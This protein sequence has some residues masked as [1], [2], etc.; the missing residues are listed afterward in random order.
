MTT[1]VV[2]RK[3][4]R[5]C[6]GADSLAKYG[7]TLESATYVANHDKLVCVGGTWI[8]PTGPASAQLIL[9]SYFRA[10]EI[11]PDFTSAQG[12]FE[13]FTDMMGALKEDYFLIPKEDERDPY[14]SLQMEMLLA[15]PAGIFG[16]YPLRSVQEFTRFYA[17]GSGAEL[18]LGAMHAVYEEEADVLRI[19]TK[20]LAA[21]AE[22]DDST[23][24]PFSLRE[25]ALSPP[26]MPPQAG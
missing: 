24:A 9:T 25:V 17:F 12:I 19:A 18:A 23:A 11:Q 20:G 26:E 14:E 13:T 6:I 15:G 21:A 5:A 8:G 10:A 3:G 4:S 7:E 16:V 1:I 2:V 22:F